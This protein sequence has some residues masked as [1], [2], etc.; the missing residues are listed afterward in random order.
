MVPPLSPRYVLELSRTLG[1]DL[2]ALRL[3]S[4][5]T[6]AALAARAGVSVRS[7]KNAERGA[8]TMRTLVQV[9]H[10]LGRGPWL[11]LLTAPVAAEPDMAHDIDRHPSRQRAHGPRH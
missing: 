4:N 1:H 11:A 5:L 10:T 7:V 6:Q 8:A 3:N 2:R 9:V